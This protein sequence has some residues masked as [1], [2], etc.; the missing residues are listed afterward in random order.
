MIFNYTKINA[1]QWEM[2][3]GYKHKSFKQEKNLKKISQMKKLMIF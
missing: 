2:L 1:E 3:P